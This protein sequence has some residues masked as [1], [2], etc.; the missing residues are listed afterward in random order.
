[1]RCKNLINPWESIPLSDYESHMQMESV[2]QL[3]TMNRMMKR[4]F[5]LHDAKSAM[6]LGV[7]GGNGL[8]HVPASPL[9]KVYAIDVNREYL[10]KCRERHPDLNHILEY[11]CTDLTSLHTTLPH[12]DL[13]I[14]NLLI[15][16]IGYDSFCR[17]VRQVSPQC[18]SCVIQLNTDS[19]FVSDS[20]YLHAFDEL[21]SVH[22][23][24]HEDQLIVAMQSAGYRLSDRQ[25][26]TLPNAKQLVRMD[27]LPS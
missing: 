11:I 3:Q 16:Y 10:Q 23:Q 9:E 14:A 17:I 4:Q 12:A 19:S 25:S 18:A 15:E 24:I 6:I 13:L 20:P 2:M 5:S 8:E 21:E 27:F 7:A 1:M 26:E 22:H